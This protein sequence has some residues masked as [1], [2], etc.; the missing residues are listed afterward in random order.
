MVVLIFVHLYCLTLLTSSESE[1]IECIPSEREALLRFKHHLTDPTNRLCSW[2][3]SNSN[4]CHWDYVV[5][6][7][8]TFHILQLHLNT[9]IPSEYDEYPFPIDYFAFQRSRFS[10]AINDS[11]VELKHLNYLDLSGNSF[12]GAIPTLLGNLG[13]LVTLDL[14]DNQFEG[15]IPSSFRKLCN[16]RHISFSNLKCNQQLSEILQILIPCVSH[17]LKTLVASTS[18][19]SGH[20]TN[21]LGMFQNLEMLDLSNNKIIGE[22]PQS[23]AKLSSLRF[24]DFSKNQLVGNPFKILASFTKLLYL[25]IDDN[26]FKGLYMKMTLR[27]SLLYVCF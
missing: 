27:I 3:A 8:L 22:L 14:S 11:L 18:Q 2:N 23:F 19:I 25:A 17:E 20:L 1:L 16:L 9:T 26:H 12:G 6:S 13:S 21:Q 5:C 4:C 7:H 15:A 10:G 24:V